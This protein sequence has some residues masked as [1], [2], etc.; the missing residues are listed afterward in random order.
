VFRDIYFYLFS[1]VHGL[2][3]NMVAYW[4][5]FWCIFYRNENK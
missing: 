5:S 1:S 3:E 4:N 2:E